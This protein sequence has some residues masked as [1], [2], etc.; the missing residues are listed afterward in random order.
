[1]KHKEVK[2][3]QEALLQLEKGRSQPA[4]DLALRIKHD[5]PS[6]PPY[7]RWFIDRWYKPA[8]ATVAVL[9]ICGLFLGTFLWRNGSHSSMQVPMVE[10]RFELFAPQAKSVELLGN[11]NNWKTGTLQLVGPDPTG[12]WLTTVYLTEGRHEY[13]FLVDGK[14]WM[15]DPKAIVSRPDGFGKMNS[16]LEVS[17]EGTVL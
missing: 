15:A 6:A 11:F 5:L 9:T 7:L 8:L 12:H 2:N 1:M 14:Y 16:V 10:V 13:L 4:S 17:R 3:L